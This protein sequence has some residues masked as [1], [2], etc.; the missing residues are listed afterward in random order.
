MSLP[1]KLLYNNKINSSYAR[2]FNSVIQAQNTSNYGLGQTAIF[3]IP[4]MRNQVL[5]GADT[6]LSIKLRVRNGA[7]LA[8]FA[9]LN[10]GGIAAAI[11]RL[12]IFSGSQLLCDIDNYGN[13]ISLLT[14][15]QSSVEHV[16]GKLAV[17]QGCGN[18]RGLQL[19]DNAAANAVVADQDF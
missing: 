11:Q 14:P 7:T 19:L 12:R 5:S 4:C 15:W 8:N 16:R 3:N 13:L 6:M 1:A 9:Y 2:N 10:K 17:L 18:N